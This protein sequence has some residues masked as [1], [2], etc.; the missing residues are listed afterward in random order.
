M[1]FLVQS[2]AVQMQ[3]VH[4]EL[5]GSMWGPWS[6]R[7]FEPPLSPQAA[8]PTRLLQLWDYEASLTIQVP[9]ALA[10]MIASNQRLACVPAANAYAAAECGV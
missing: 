8:T 6:Q 7:L 2:M 3:R 4:A 9:A 1:L 5:K 10:S